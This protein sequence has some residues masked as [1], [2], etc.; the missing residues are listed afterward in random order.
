[1][2]VCAC[3]CA[4]VC[5]SVCAVCVPV[6][7]ALCACVPACVLCVC[8]RACERLRWEALFLL[9]PLWGAGVGDAGLSAGEGEAGQQLGS[10]GLVGLSVPPKGCRGLSGREGSMAGLWAPRRWPRP[11]RQAGHFMCSR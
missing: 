11:P 4:H 5:A 9:Y 10:W 8:L 3:V 6:C 7:M 1:M 2:C